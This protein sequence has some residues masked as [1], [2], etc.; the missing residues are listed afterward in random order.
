MTA[1]RQAAQQ[2]LDW[3]SNKDFE[4]IRRRIM[5]EAYELSDRDVEGYN[6]IKVMCS[7]VQKMLPPQRPWVGLEPEEIL[8]LFDRNNVYG[9]KWVEFARAVEAKLKEK[10]NG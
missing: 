2:A 10:N 5:E 1:P 3:M 9:S 4:P 7:D 6:S 8:D